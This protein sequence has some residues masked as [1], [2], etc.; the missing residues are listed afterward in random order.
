MNSPTAY[1]REKC[2]NRCRPAPYCGDG[3]LNSEYG[4]KCD[5]G[6]GNTGMPGACKP[7]CSARVPNPSCG[8]SIVQSNEQCDQGGG[9]NGTAGS[10][11]DANCRFKCGNGAR[12]PGEACDLGAAQNTGAYGT[13][14]ANCTLAPFCGDGM[15]NGVEQCD[16]GTTGNEANPYGTNKCTTACTIAPYCGDGRIDSVFKEECDSAPRCNALCKNIIFE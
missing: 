11:C 8:D 6:T 14:N 15:K 9:V 13:C 7:D 12:D 16:L 10:T 4:E 1:G 2:T 5:D 3:A